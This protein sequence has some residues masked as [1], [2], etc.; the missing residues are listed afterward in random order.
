MAYQAREYISQ[1]DVGEFDIPHGKCLI[2][3]NNMD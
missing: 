3:L 1:K 2:C